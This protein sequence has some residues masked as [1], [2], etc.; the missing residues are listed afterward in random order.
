ML[1]TS[2][3]EL[4]KYVGFLQLHL[5][6]RYVLQGCKP[7]PVDWYSQH[8]VAVAVAMSQ[9]TLIGV[10]ACASRTATSP[11]NALGL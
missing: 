5:Q 11:D 3:M 8:Q 9:I 7:T 10:P 2:C 1:H 6:T 4:I